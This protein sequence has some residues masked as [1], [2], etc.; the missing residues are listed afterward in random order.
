MEKMEYDYQCDFFFNFFFKINAIL[1]LQ[2]V[3]DIPTNYSV[4]PVVKVE[5]RLLRTQPWIT[6]RAGTWK[7]RNLTTTPASGTLSVK[8][9][10]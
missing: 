8:A 1:R 5:F 6:L 10:V 9:I 2:E 3:I 7:C 4:L